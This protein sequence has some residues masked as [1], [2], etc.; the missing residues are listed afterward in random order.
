MVA[1]L[2]R[3]KLSLLRNGLRRSVPQLVGMVLAALYALGVVG[4][5]V[6]GLVALRLPPTSGPPAR[7]SSCSAVR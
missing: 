4:L 2:V 3:L 5:A 6:A 1:H 7:W